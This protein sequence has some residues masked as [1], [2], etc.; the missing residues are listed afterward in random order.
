MTETTRVRFAPSPT[1]YLHVGGARTALFNWLFARHEGG[2][3]VLR[4]EDTDRERSRSELSD[5]ILESLT[6][7][8]LGWDEG[9]IHQADFLDRHQADA[10]RLIE[11]GAAYR[12][13]CTQE[14]LEERRR[15]AIA[16]AGGY[17]YDGRCKGIS[18][19]K[20]DRRAA[21]GKPHVVRFLMPPGETVWTDAVGG[22]TRFN[23]SDIEDFILLRSDATPTYNLA[24]VS[25]DH[26]LRITHVIR[27]A[28]HIS[29]TPKQIQ[30]YRALGA[31]PPLFCH[32]PL[33]LGPDAKRLSKRHGATAVG[34][35]RKAGFLAS[36]MLNFLALLGWSPG[37]DVEYMGV[38]ELVR[39]FGLARLNK[40]PAVFDHQKLIWLNGE[41]LSRTPTSTLV[42]Q[43]VPLLVDA[44]IASH[45]ELTTRRAWLESVLDL[46]KVRART[47]PDVV[48]QARPFFSGVVEPEPVA[49]AKHWKDP[50]SALGRLARLRETLGEMEGWD[51]GVLEAQVRGIAEDMGSGAGKLI[52]PL[53]VA[54]TGSAVSPGIF[55]VMTVM[56]R[57]LVL[58]RIDL[59][60]NKLRVMA[61]RERS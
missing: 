27:G 15:Q 39:R 35:Y 3:F 43:I 40:K 26:A 32:V 5:A 24:V 9:P 12:C 37:D 60:M 13:F 54:L 20:S 50:R 31:E 61:E 57:D 59:A 8:G 17:V 56:G 55:E 51:E 22:E 58:E 49:V 14:E 41:H 18:A 44:G 36:T 19:D 10:A 45:D 33:I 47:L 6:W 11:V 30:I 52:H 53:R 34:E 16:S 48:S 23:N 21:A 1:G 2:V 7:L 46:V 29:N 28:D 38:D 25:D 42:K 4:I